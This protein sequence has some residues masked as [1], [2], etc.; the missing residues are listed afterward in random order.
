MVTKPI[1]TVALHCWFDWPLTT[2]LTGVNSAGAALGA[3][4]NAW[5]ADRFSRKY[6]IQIGAVILVIGAGIGAGSVD[7]EML[8]VSRFIS[9]WGIGII[10]SVIPM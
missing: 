2:L 5:S 9:G 10:I 8:M 7:V 6:T 4:F 1:A 3:L